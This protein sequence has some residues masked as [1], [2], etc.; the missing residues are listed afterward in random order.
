MTSSPASTDLVPAAPRK[1]SR[2][3]KMLGMG[4]VVVLIAGAGGVAALRCPWVTQ[5]FI[6]PAATVMPNTQSVQNARAIAALED[7]VR[8]LEARTAAPVQPAAGNDGTAAN[9][10]ADTVK[11][12][13]AQVAQLQGESRNRQR[14]TRQ[15]VAAA[16]AFWDLRQ[17]VDAGAPFATR[18]AAFDDAV[19]AGSAANAPDIDTQTAILFSHTA[20]VATAAQLRAD[21]MAHEPA[22]ANAPVADAADQASS[23]R[24]EWK[25]RALDALSRL[26][27]VR[28]VHN[29]AFDAVE[30]ALARGDAA[31]AQSAF[32]R[33]PDDAQKD[34]ASW[35]AQLQER[36]AVDAALNRLATD[37]GASSNDGASP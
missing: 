32:T 21:L 9:A 31:A 24:E 3:R 25:A 6:A 16:L 19:K 27:S 34:L 2:S 15:W 20:G 12:L 28:P 33:L 29:A 11:T 10:L 7:R 26:I 37:F 17:T 23:W 35:D 13:Q 1:K 14:Q 22:I 5:H 18:L 8:M 30:D 4:L 36:V